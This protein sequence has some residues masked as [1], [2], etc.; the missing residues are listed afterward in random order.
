MWLTKTQGCSWVRR[1]HLIQFLL[2]PHLQ[3]YN[4]LIQILL[5]SPC[6]SIWSI[7]YHKLWLPP[8]SLYQYPP[9][10]VLCI[11]YVDFSYTRFYKYKPIKGTLE[12][13]N[14]S[15]QFPF[16]ISKEYSTF[17]T[18]NFISKKPNSYTVL[19]S[20]FIHFLYQYQ[21]YPWQH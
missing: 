7:I 21:T 9:T 5:I 12:K 18:N 13:T 15:V 4:K 1:P 10:H 19:C 6:K 3:L 16:K 8:F 17:R 14:K 2:P 20:I 11:I